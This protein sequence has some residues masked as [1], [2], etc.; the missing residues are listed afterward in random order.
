MKVTSSQQAAMA[1]R[2]G[3]LQLIACAGSG[4]TETVAQRVANLLDPSLKPQYLPSN[5]VAFTFTEKAAA[6]LKQRIV[7]RTREARGDLPGMAEM[8]VG[9]IHAFCLDLLKTELP[10][11]LK[12]ELLNEVQQSL[13]VDR[14][15]R[16]SGLTTTKDLNGLALKRFQDTGRYLTALG[17]LREADLNQAHLTGV[18]VADALTPYESFLHGKRYFDYSSIL[19]LAVRALA[20]NAE[21]RAR[22]AARVKH[23]IVD[24]YQDVNPVQ[25]RLIRLL[26]DLG[27]SICV[28]GDDDQ[29]IYQWRG[30]D[31]QSILTFSQRYDRVKEIR[32][33]ENFRS[34][35]GIVETAR[36]FISQ[37]TARLPKQMEPTTA[38]AYEAGDV[39]ALAF[40][41]PE[42]EAA[43]IAMS[44]KSLLGVA[45]T[46]PGGNT[47]GLSY[48]DMAILLR[49]VK[50]NGETITRA[51]REHDIPAIV[52]GMNNLFGTLE[53]EA[54]RQ[55]YYFMADRPSVD[56]DAVVRAWLNADLGLEPREVRNAVKQA[57]QVRNE[58]HD[59]AHQGDWGLRNLQRQFLTF[60]EDVGL[61]EETVPR[62]RGEVVF[63]NLGKFSQLISDFET[64]YFQTDPA[65][66]YAEFANFL[67]FHA[68]DAYPE[69]W[70]NN[71][72]ANPNAVRVM[73][74]HQAKGMQWPV[75]FLPALIRNR[76]PAAK[77][78]GRT[79]WSILPKAAVVDQS[80][81]EGTIEDER[82]LFYV[83]MTRA[84]KF[85]HMTWAP[86]KGSGNRYLK[87]SEFWDNVLASMYVKRRRPDY[88]GRAKLPE[89][90]RSSVA[91]VTLTFSELKYFFE[92]AYQFKLRIL[93]G[94]NPPI[95]EALGYGKS[96]HDALAEVHARAIRG[97]IPKGDEAAQLVETH[98][99][100]P[101]SYQA[102]RD[103]LRQS[104][105][106][107]VRDYLKDNAMEMAHLE[108]AEKIVEIDL[109]DGI[110][111][112]GRI[113]LVRR[114]DTGQT[115][116]VDLKSTDR[117]QAED[118]TERQLHIY[119]LGYRELTGRDADYVEIYNLDERKKKP[120][121]VDDD[122]I[123]DVKADVQKAAA[124]LRAN[125]MQASAS[126]R[127]CPSCDFLRLCSTGQ[128]FVQGKKA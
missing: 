105:E 75:V 43:H 3:H 45:F 25:E 14:N 53:A 18:S 7:E 39:V 68:G 36:T 67:E 9:T 15:S 86:I 10:Q 33:Q 54:A 51:L 22:I 69:G 78:G 115:T 126:Q 107:V 98:L 60:L 125:Q 64:I 124:A 5:I 120:R 63:Y 72:Y 118:V 35:P 65:S 122:F 112:A 102:L 106:R 88:S 12:Y 16:Q 49:S 80:R 82:R 121:S 57:E 71:Q 91:N 42:E 94:F 38:Q 119:A 90:P 17:I 59:N 31:V 103:T 81:F 84:Q 109:G 30:S 28:V 116:I 61:R 34:S 1:H 127:S 95:H 99:N 40:D 4:K 110:T 100:L 56:N 66:K 104:A 47:R 108:F 93:Y 83:A 77:V 114:K 27:A 41:S 24:E 26:A 20:E 58:I 44:I 55:L 37:N 62:N 73:T 101:Y 32:L 74:V 13:I 52:V 89:R 117:A 113:D 23:V 85:L 6:E 48:S 21:V 97:D 70:Q 76:F 29:T 19:D 8:F 50:A 2:D 128:K 96:L 46:D 111:V 123:T 11:Y 92:C 79:V 87:Q